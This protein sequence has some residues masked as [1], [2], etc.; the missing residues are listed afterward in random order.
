MPSAAPLTSYLTTQ[1]S[2]QQDG[3]D[4]AASKGSEGNTEGRVR[5]PLTAPLG[6]ESLLSRPYG[7]S[8]LGTCLSRAS[9]H[10]QTAP[11][12]L[13]VRRRGAEFGKPP[14]PDPTGRRG[15]ER[16]GAST[17]TAAKKR[18]TSAHPRV[19]APTGWTF[20]PARSCCERRAAPRGRRRR[21]RRK[22]REAAQHSA[23]VAAPPSAPRWRSLTP[24]QGRGAAMQ[25]SRLS[26]PIDE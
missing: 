15:Q 23:P 14:G 19:P 11:H 10:P 1:G 6:P 9:P 4:H 26:Q 25:I 8:V 18:V 24:V 2:S 7:P 21:R 3:T 20:P 12:P 5:A 22:R 13:T 17:G 16:A